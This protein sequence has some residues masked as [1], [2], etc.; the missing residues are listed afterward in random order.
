MS[1]QTVLCDHKWACRHYFLEGH[2]AWLAIW[3]MAR[4]TTAANLVVVV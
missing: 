2:A 1:R 4:S 3:Q